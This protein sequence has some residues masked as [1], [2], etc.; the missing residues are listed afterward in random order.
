MKKRVLVT[1][2]YGFLG[3]YVIDELVLNG[4]HV[5]AFGRDI[6]KMELLKC[7]DVDIC[8]GDFRRLEDNLKATDGVDFVLH[9]GALSTV[10]G[11]RQDFIDTNVD[12]TMRLVEACR[13]NKVKRFVYVSSPSIYSGKRDRLNIKENEYD[14][15]NKL[16]YYIESKIMAEQQ[17]S[18]VNDLDWVIVRPRGLF[19]VGD[20]SIIPRL[21]KA[22][23]KIGVPLF[24][25]GEILVDITCVENVAYALRLCLESDNAVG[26]IYNVTNGEARKFKQILEQ[27]FD[28]IGVKPCYLKLNFNFVFAYSC[29]LE[30]VYKLLHIYKEPILTKYNVCTLGFSQTLDISKAKK[31][32]GYVPKMT[33]DEGIEK[34]AKEYNKN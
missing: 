16:N 1:G 3:K 30:F 9:C 13:R 8:I 24:N 11:R 20:T 2:P 7:D 29:I 10:W 26:N 21:I 28:K 15:G 6:K 34:Y 14:P 32:L 12:G 23:S 4:Y 27:L 5:V 22:N 17:L 33:L 31:D 25:K 19:G 18:Q